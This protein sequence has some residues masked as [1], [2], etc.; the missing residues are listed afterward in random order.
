MRAA[1]EVWDCTFSPLLVSFPCRPSLLHVALPKAVLQLQEAIWW[2]R[3][4][5]WGK[6]C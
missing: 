5:S 4:G 3:T 1:F 6:S 2:N